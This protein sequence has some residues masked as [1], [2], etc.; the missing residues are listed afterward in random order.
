LFAPTLASGDG[1]DG[2]YRYADLF[3]KEAGHFW[4]RARNRLVLQALQRD[5]PRAGSFFEI[6]C[7]TGF[8]LSG[9]ARQFPDWALA[10]SDVQTVGLAFARQRLPGA[11]L[12]QMDGRQIPFVDHFDVIGAF[13]VLEHIEDDE[14]VLG[15]MFRATR[16]GGGLLLTVPQHPFLWSAMDTIG[17][18]KRR[19]TRSQLLRKVRSA[20]FDVIRAT[21][22]V[23]LLLPVLALSRLMPR[24]P[25]SEF[26]VMSEFRIHP[27]LNRALEAVLWIETALVSAGVSFPAGG[28]LLVTARR[29][30]AEGAPMAHPLAVGQQGR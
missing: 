20:G 29:P 4:F 1:T 28:S 10:G 17:H 30:S 2:E 3:E 21:S 6:G 19:Y 12:F 16:P 23:S 7:G 9:V 8:V 14:Q 13:D 11:F 26:D 24:R 18:H 25:D 27:V 5:F 15:Q 22:F